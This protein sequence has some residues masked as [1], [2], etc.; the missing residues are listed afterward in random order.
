MI[1]I[2]HERSR[3]QLEHATELV[4]DGRTHLLGVA[5]GHPGDARVLLLACIDVDVVGP[6]YGVQPWRRS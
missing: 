2:L 5:I 1:R 3:A 4:R 6:V